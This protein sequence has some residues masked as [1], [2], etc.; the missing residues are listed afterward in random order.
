MNEYYKKITYKE[1]LDTKS[2]D[3]TPSEILYIA[4]NTD[5]S[6]EDILFFKGLSG[7]CDVNKN[8]YIYKLPDEWYIVI[9]IWGLGMENEDYYK[10]DQMEG[11]I[12]LLNTIKSNNENNI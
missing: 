10:C 6:Y 8:L 2:D 4:N 7:I 12:Q 3:F 11:L 1:F 5:H 9:Y